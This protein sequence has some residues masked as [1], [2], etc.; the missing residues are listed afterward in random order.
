MK[1]PS[2]PGKDWP[3]LRDDIIGLGHYSARRSFFPELQQ[4]VDQLQESR[5]QLLDIVEF[6]PDATWVI[7]REGRVIAWNKACE[8]LTG[9]PAADMLGKGDYEYSL[10]FYGKRRPLLIDVALQPDL[11]LESPYPGM[12]RKNETLSAEVFLPGVGSGGTHL[13]M[14]AC[15]LYDAS[16]HVAGAI[17]SVRDITDRKRIEASLAA[18][19]RKYR[20]LF[21]N[22]TAGFALQE[23]IF[24]EDGRPVDYRFLEAN[25]AF[26]RLTGIP[27][28][29]LIG[30]TVREVIPAIEPGWIDVYG[31]VAVTGEPMSYQDYVQ[32]LG[33]HYDCWA[34][35]PE[36]GKVAVVFT[37]ITARRI[38]EEARE[39]SERRMTEL[40]E[41][42]HLAAVTLDP[43]GKVTFCNG[44]LLRLTGW[45]REE[46]IGVDWFERFIPATDRDA[47]RSVF[48]SGVASGTLPPQHEN[49]I[50]TRDGRLRTIVWQNTVL[51]APDGTVSGVASIG[52]DVTDQ[53][54]LEEQLRQSQKMEAVGQL[55]GGVAHDFNNLLTVII[56][57]GNMAKMKMKDDSPER[58]HLDQVLDAAGRATELTRGLLAFSRK[59]VMT[60]RPCDLGELIRDVEKFLRRIIGEDIRLDTRLATAS[61]AMLVDKV[62][63]EQVLINLATNAR[64][65]MPKGG[66]LSISTGLR[67]LDD[68]FLRI[69][70]YGS[71]GRFAEIAVSDTGVGMPEETLARIF[72]PFYTTKE[73]GKGTGLGLSIVYGI[74]KQ[75]N[76]YITVDSTRGAGTTFRIYLPL[77]ASSPEAEAASASRRIVPAGGS[78]TIL[79]AEDDPVVRG[80]I[81]A[82]LREFGYAVVLAADGQEAVEQY[83]AHRGRIRL[84][85]MD[86]IMP[87]KNGREACEEIRRM[88]PDVKVL[89]ASGYTADIIRNRGELEEGADLVFKPIDPMA[90]AAKIREVLDRD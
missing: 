11:S 25:P 16:G 65:A 86:L 68:R 21:E 78:E 71:P 74:V 32:G 20:Q 37:D 23:M 46:A 17:E 70:G 83:I 81:E 75:H 4:R 13:S 77:A 72:E 48:R 24:D 61:P 49:P 62:Q 29:S 47:I 53:R 82:V 9:I 38:A 90:L 31:R 43:Q 42:V 27:V 41:S 63:I 69:H 87:R 26:E 36:R 35:S 73:P 58:L 59:Q 52:H 84:L 88:A 2:D 79:V 34:F 80:L 28:A 66:T 12:D 44:Y 33:R 57:Y 50:V 5:Q 40:L 85:L 64:D 30:R 45:S 55:A 1:R 19:E 6:L 7:D 15:A 60:P 10:P 18:S 3:R 51:H 14:T 89:F 54:S 76:G 22:M 8:T 67:D 56:G 39:S